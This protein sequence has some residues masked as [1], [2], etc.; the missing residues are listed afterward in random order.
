MLVPATV[1]SRAVP[2]AAACQHRL[3]WVSSVRVSR[4][5]A[6]LVTNAPNTAP[7]PPAPGSARAVR[8]PIACSTSRKWVRGSSS[9]RV[10]KGVGKRSVYGR[11]GS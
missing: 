1:R 9:T 5:S 6:T 11:A 3:W 10:T 2:S 4:C 7:M 8:S